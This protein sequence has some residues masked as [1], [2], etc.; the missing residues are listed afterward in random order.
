MAST[1]HGQRK[2]PLPLPRS[3]REK[4]QGTLGCRSAD[5]HLLQIGV[6]VPNTRRK[7]EK[8]SAKMSESHRILQR[9]Y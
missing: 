7:G 8:E 5:E 3:A 6:W 9:E 4:E 2:L 1:A